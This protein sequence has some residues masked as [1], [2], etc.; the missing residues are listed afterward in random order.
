MKSS[1]FSGTIV[2]PKTNFEDDDVEL[3]SFS[4]R[5]NDAGSA[6]LGV[7]IKGKMIEERDLGIFVK[8]VIAG[9]AASKV[10]RLKYRK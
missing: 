5:L 1:G 7:T 6:G 3:L 9:G 8:S 2:L 4:I 10:Q